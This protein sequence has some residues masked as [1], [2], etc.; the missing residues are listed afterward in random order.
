MLYFMLLMIAWQLDTHGSG[1]GDAPDELDRLGPWIV[2]WM[3]ALS[4]AYALW[5]YHQPM[6]H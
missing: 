6:T 1:G 2:A 3:V 4:V 5:A